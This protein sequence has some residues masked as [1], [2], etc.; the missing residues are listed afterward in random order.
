MKYN[1]SNNVSFF[2][3]FYSPYGVSYL[4]L[5]NR[6]SL[7][8]LSHGS[9]NITLLLLVRDPIVDCCLCYDLSICPGCF[10]CCFLSCYLLS[11]LGQYLLWVE[12]PAFWVWVIWFCP[13][14][15]LALCS[16]FRCSY[17]S[18][19]RDPCETS[20]MFCKVFSW[21]FLFL[22]PAL[23]GWQF[24]FSGALNLHWLGYV[25][26]AGW[27]PLHGFVPTH[28]LVTL[29]LNYLFLRLPASCIS[30]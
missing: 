4:N 23:S 22:F 11:Q 30:L 3:N 12:V 25:S 7:W 28:L 10:F 13:L 20:C 16:V 9:H 14:I 18:P 1:Q 21:S 24:S 26:P 29:V 5:S 8:F 15:L 6:C 19:Y 27:G 17:G 2:P